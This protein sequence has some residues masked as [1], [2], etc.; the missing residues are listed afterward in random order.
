MTTDIS[1]AQF[2]S[3][4]PIDKIISDFDGNVTTHSVPAATFSGGFYLPKTDSIQIINPTGKKALMTMIYTYDNVN[5][6]PSKARLYQ[7]GNPVPAGRIG[8]VVGEAVNADYIWFYFTHYFG[9]Q[10]DFTM[11]W[12][13]DTIL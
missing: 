8:A 4:F 9:S 3:E 1:K 7:P 13:L 5:Y 2:S 6:Y 12:V 11:F 10:V